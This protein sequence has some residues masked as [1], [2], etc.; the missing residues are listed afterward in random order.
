MKL[1][2]KKQIQKIPKHKYHK[3]IHHLHEEHKISKR[4][5]FYMKEYGPRSH[6]AAEIIKDSLEILI[7]TSVISTIGGIGL[8]SIKSQLFIF[9][10]LLILV[11]ALNKMIGDFG[12]IVS[13]RF[14]TSLFLGK[15]KT[16]WWKSELVKKLFTK[17]FVVAIISSLYLGIF[18]YAISLLKG[19]IL[20]ENLLI[21]ILSISI[22]TTLSLFSIIFLVS[23]V[24]GYW[25][26]KRGEDPNNFLIPITTSLADLGSIF[27]FAI[28]I[29]VFL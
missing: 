17:L 3:L 19:S 20:T 5:L 12:A 13:L 26:F 4:T 28:L 9:L 6:A 2:P 16:G 11:P 29:S 21:K 7:L 18:S 14:T 24:G 22:L 25:I 27:V 15:V 8:Q 10:P 23:I 1:I